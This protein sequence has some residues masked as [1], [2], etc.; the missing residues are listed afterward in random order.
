MVLT[1]AGFSRSRFIQANCLLKCT[2]CKFGRD[3]SK[4][5]SLEIRHLSK[6]ASNFHA[7]LVHRCSC[8][9]ARLPAR[10]A[11]STPPS[12][13]IQRRESLTAVGVHGARRRRRHPPTSP[14]SFVTRCPPVLGAG[15]GGLGAFLCAFLTV[16]QRCA[17]LCML[18]TQ[19]CVLQS[20]E[21]WAH[22]R[23]VLLSVF[24]SDVAPLCSSAL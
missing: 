24:R 23:G 11:S 18:H 16:A 21:R 15:R 3:W 4:Q 2:F 12:S 7:L 6:P 22:R 10:S 5:K 13:L 17:L 9:C 1:L 19:R 14:S 20:G 8:P